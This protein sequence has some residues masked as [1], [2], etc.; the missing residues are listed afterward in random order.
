MKI[1]AVS[2]LIKQNNQKKAESITFGSLHMPPKLPKDF[3]GV[4]EKSLAYG[5]LRKIVYQEGKKSFVSLKNKHN[6]EIIREFNP[7]EKLKTLLKTKVNGYNKQL[8]YGED[9]ALQTELTQHASGF[10]R[11]A[12]YYQGLINPTKKRVTAAFN[13]GKINRGFYDK[14]GV[15]RSIIEYTSNTKRNKFAFN[16][17]G[18]LFRIVEEEILKDGSR[19]RIFYDFE[20]KPYK[21]IIKKPDGTIIRSR[22]DTT[23]EIRTTIRP[24]KSET[25]TFINPEGKTDK[26]IESFPDIDRTKITRFLDDKLAEITT[27]DKKEGI[28]KL[29]F[30]GDERL[31]TSTAIK[32]EETIRLKFGKNGDI[33]DIE[34]R[35][36]ATAPKYESFNELVTKA[37]PRSPLLDET[38]DE[39]LNVSML[40]KT[41]AG[42]VYHP[43]AFK[44][45]PE[46]FFKFKKN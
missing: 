5:A 32:E 29:I 38:L 43:S 28:L 18:K 27:I 20:R 21:M 16:A 7:M 15:L 6:D 2:G 19:S 31:Y 13:N 17:K 40:R 34:K 44:L 4:V 12:E 36:H 26:I 30:V 45:D 35:A 25:S 42:T 14:Q 8:V 11:F 39:A 33:V 1:F 46:N 41:P 3:T 22:L 10:T 37:V 9:K 24:D 23:G